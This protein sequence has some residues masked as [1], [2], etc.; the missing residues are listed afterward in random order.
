MISSEVMKVAVACNPLH[1]DSS[2]CGKF[3][4][5]TSVRKQFVCIVGFSVQ[6]ASSY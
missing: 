2:R 3:F 6:L 1:Q 4:T 5:L